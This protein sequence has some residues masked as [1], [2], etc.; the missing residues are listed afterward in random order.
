MQSSSLL[1]P[2]SYHP[3]F[4]TRIS[5][6]GHENCTL[7]LRYELPPILFVD[8]YQLSNRAETYSYKYAGPLNLEPP[9]VLEIEVPLHVRYGHTSATG[10]MFQDA[11]LSWPDALFPCPLSASTSRPRAEL[12]KIPTEFAAA[13]EGKSIIRLRSPEGVIPIE[14]IR[15]P[16]GSTADVRTV[17]IG[18]TVVIISAFLFLVH[19]VRRTVVRLG[20]ATARLSAKKQ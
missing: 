5:A 18:T 8:P 6:P 20:S 14:T 12:P 13:F 1:H 15:T 7:N 17:E 11:K 3:V 16:V 10:T 2:Y 9:G 19:A 4:K